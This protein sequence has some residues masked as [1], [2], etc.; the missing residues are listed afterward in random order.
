MMTSFMV[1]GSHVMIVGITD[2]GSVSMIGGIALGISG[3]VERFEPVQVR[4]ICRAYRRFQRLQFF[5]QLR[6]LFGVRDGHRY[7]RRASPRRMAFSISAQEKHRPE[8]IPRT[9]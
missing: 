5:Q 9:R 2:G 3:F 1:S 4:K 8:P 6:Q 7:A